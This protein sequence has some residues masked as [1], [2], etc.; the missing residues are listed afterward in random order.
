MNKF[1]RRFSI[2]LILILLFQSII[3]SNTFS[4][5]LPTSASNETASGNPAILVTTGAGTEFVQNDRMTLGNPDFQTDRFI[6]KYKYDTGREKL[7]NKFAKKGFKRIDKVGRTQRLDVITLDQKRKLKDF[8]EDIKA[9]ALDSEIEYVQ[10]DYLMSLNSNDPLYGGQWGIQNNSASLGLDYESTTPATLS[11]VCDTSIAVAWEKSTGE[12]VTVA[13]IDTGVDIEHEDLIENIWINS[14]EIPNNGLDDDDNGYID[15]VNGWNFTEQTNVVYNSADASGDTHGTHVAGIIAAVKDNDKGVAG[16]APSSKIMP[17]KV[18][19]GGQAYTSDIIS[20]IEYAESMNVMVVNCS[21]GGTEENLALKEAIQDSDILFVC[22]AGN[23]STNIDTTPIYPAAYDC[24]NIISVVSV[25]RY[26]ALSSFSNYGVSGTDMAAPGEEILSTLPGNGYGLNSGTS[27]A[28]AFVSAEAALLLSLNSRLGGSDLKTCIIDTSTKLDSLI[29]KVQ[30]SRLINAANA[31][32]NVESITGTKKSFTN[33]QLKLTKAQKKYID[34]I[35]SIK[36]F[37]EATKKQMK[38][39]TD[40]LDIDLKLLLETEKQGYSVA[41]TILV[42]QIVQN[43]DLSYQEIKN[44][45]KNYED[46]AYLYAASNQYAK[47]MKTWNYTNEIIRELK[48]LF[49]EGYSMLDIEK[50]SVIALIFDT[51]L[52]DIM[53]RGNDNIQEEMD[54]KDYTREEIGKI[55]NLLIENY[56]SAKW[57]MQYIKDKGI[58]INEFSNKVADFYKANL[59]VIE[60]EQTNTTNSGMKLFSSTQ[61]SDTY[62]APFSY[63]IYNDDEIERNTGSLLIENVDVNLPGKNGLDVKLVS[64]YDSDEDRYSEE[65]VKAVDNLVTR[66]NVFVWRDKYIFYGTYQTEHYIFASYYNVSLADYIRLQDIYNKNDLTH[67]ENDSETGGTKYVYS[68]TAEQRSG[69][70]YMQR[71]YDYTPTYNMADSPLGKGWGFAFDSIEV[72][73]ENPYYNNYENAYVYLPHKGIGKFLHL[74][75]GEVYLIGDDLKLVGYKLNDMQLKLDST[76]TNGQNVTSYYALVYKNGIKKYFGNDGRLLAVKDRY[77]NT[78]QYQH[79]MINDHYV[80]TKIID[81]LNR[82]ININYDIANNK[83]VV[84]APVNYKVTYNLSVDGSIRN[85]DNGTSK[86]NTYRVNSRVDS[87]NRTTTYT[88][89]YWGYRR[90]LYKEYV[91]DNGDSAEGSTVLT[92]ITYPTGMFVE[93]Q[94]VSTGRYISAGYEYYP[95]VIKR[96]VYKKSGT[97]QNCLKYCYV[98]SYTGYPFKEAESNSFPWIKDAAPNSYK[99]IVTDP[100][101]NTTPSM[102]HE[103]D[104]EHKFI[105]QKSYR[106]RSSAVNP[107]DSNDLMIVNYWL[108]SSIDYSYNTTDRQLIQKITRTYTIPDYTTSTFTLDTQNKNKYILKVEDFTYDSYGS[109]IKY[110]GPEAARTS[111]TSGS[112]VIAQLT[113]AEN[114]PYKVTYAYNTENYNLL[115]SKEYKKDVNTTIKQVNTLTSDYKGIAE[116]TMQQNGTIKSKLQYLYDTWGNV[117]N[118]KTYTDE[119]VWSN[120]IE[121]QYSYL[122]NNGRSDFNGAYIT[123]KSAIEISGGIATGEA[124]VEKYQYDIFGNIEN[125]MDPKGYITT[126]QYDLLRRQTLKTNPDLTTVSNNYDDTNNIRTMKNENNT[127]MQYIYDEF[128]NLIGEYDVSGGHSLKQYSY[129]EFFRLASEM[130]NT[131]GYDYRKIDYT[132]Y[133]DGRFKDK[134][135]KGDGDT[136]LAEEYYLFDDAFDINGDGKADYSKTTK[137]VVGDS[138]SPSVVTTQYTDRNGLPIREGKF[139]NGEELYSTYNYDY[140]GNKINEK[141]ARANKENWT[142]SYTTQ[143]EYDFAGRLTKTQDVNSNISTIAYDAAG[144]VKT[145]TDNIGNQASPIYSTLYEYDVMG[146]VVKESMPVEKVGSTIYY[147]VK[148]YAYDMN[149][150][151]IFEKISRNKPGETNIYKQTGYQYDNRNRMIMVISYKDKVPLNYIQDDYEKVPESYTQYYYDNV[152]N[153][154]RMYTGL[155][156]PL[157]ISGKDNVTGPDVVYSTTKYEYDRFNKLVSMTD[158]LGKIETYTYGINGN[159]TGKTDRNG[160]VFTIAYDG[161][162]RILSNKVVTPDGSG[163]VTNTFTYTIIGNRLATSGGGIY[164]AYLYDELGRFKSESETGGIVKT[165]TYDANNNRKTFVLT[166]NGVTKTN[167]SYDYDK[168]NRLWKVYENSVLLATYDYDANGNRNTLTYNTSGNSTSYNYNLANKLTLLTNKQGATTISSYAYTYYLDGNQASKTDLA[169]KVTNYM[170]DATGR[171]SGESPQGESAIAYTYDDSNNRKTMSVGASSTTYDYDLNN[172]LTKEIKVTGDTTVITS[173]TYDNN[174]NQIFKGVEIIKPIVSGEVETIT[175]TILGENEDDG[176]ISLN[177][178]DGLNQLKKVTT[179]NS[180]TEYTYNSDGLRSSKTVNVIATK[181]IWDGDQIALDLDEVGT[182]K[183]KYIRG[184]NLIAAEDG[185]NIRKFYLYN[186]HGDVVQLTNTVGSVIKSYNYDAFGNEK[187][188]DSIDTNVFRYCGEYFDKE[189]G[190]YYLRARYY[191]PTIGRFISEDSVWGKDSDPLSLN[192]YTYCSSNPIAFVDPTGHIRQPGYVN[193]VWYEDPD[194]AEFGSDSATYQSLVT[195]GNLWTG[196][197]DLSKRD[198]YHTSA[199][200]IRGLAR[201]SGYDFSLVS[202]A[203]FAADNSQ[204]IYYSSEYPIQRLGGYCDLYD[205]A[206][207]AVSDMNTIKMEFNDWRIQFW[208]SG[209]YK[210]MGLGGEMGIYTRNKNLG[211]FGYYDCASPENFMAMSFSLYAG[212]STTP[213]FSRYDS[214]HWWLTGFVPGYEGVSASDIRMIGS[215]T[216]KDQYMVNSFTNSLPSS[217]N[218]TTNGL[219]VDFDW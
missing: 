4:P 175:A 103:Y 144:R 212:D 157:T 30:G 132:Y 53:A 167:T 172:R 46:L 195:L 149:G 184:I 208:K 36:S 161:L 37:A 133:D 78:I 217:V 123:S 17:L 148:K 54:T 49:V 51:R 129:D 163:N 3:L 22:A 6:I 162:Y 13:V 56:I 155:S 44:A 194:A 145:K 20:A 135:T 65:E 106:V 94:Y 164:I 206:F 28:T 18:F 158:P 85:R 35:I 89:N 166:Q 190:T 202:R 86:Y 81:T 48:Q 134:I 204:G 77:K 117:A 152:G 142:E 169:N 105:A 26:G 124:I 136:T 154:L 73:N 171:L 79:T 216:L 198:G 82:E 128:G 126:F 146:R 97:Q 185:T 111:S 27:M 100:D 176:G 29:G 55:S 193:G 138:N 213:I 153:K 114:D 147:S 69:Y 92:K 178:Y 196:T 7:Y 52:F 180:I 71:V 74:E 1:T 99:F 130:N 66:Y 210:S 151:L 31:V 170:Y 109:L 14:G 205:A 140:F 90:L 72:V 23:S 70:G 68:L 8:K 209:D 127:Q 5:F 165:Y 150:N 9:Q 62:K 42:A 211:Y 38:I 63:E 173:Y 131:A 32:E 118:E 96:M 177:E 125:Y 197:N 191:D 182:I 207:G 15:D 174:G 50:P 110:W 76:Y 137:T 64:R 139:L 16:A 101:T 33:K 192:L 41:D 113:N 219:R 181:H 61:Q 120:Y 143:Y 47:L 203:T 201:T 19:K 186:G 187:N 34:T 43:T 200:K 112:S 215:I 93:Y 67:Y 122:D 75:S 12:G 183:G 108:F 115:M 80:I 83:V 179:G 95:K 141:S 102:E 2:V 88:Y 39:I 218:Y 168:M 10:P 45:L 199:D 214:S 159:M 11:Y 104:T 156:S 91:Y 119:G 40:F 25:N 160:N 59:E 107:K 188:T 58:T 189:T 87:C 84:S 24:D 98:G 60:M 57:F 116:T 121:E 21:W